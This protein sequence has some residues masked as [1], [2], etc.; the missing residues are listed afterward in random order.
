MCRNRFKRFTNIKPHL[1]IQIITEPRHAV[2]TSVSRLS[3]G[4]KVKYIIL[5]YVIYRSIAERKLEVDRLSF[6]TS[7]SEFKDL[8][9]SVTLFMMFSLMRTC[10]TF[11][12]Y[13]LSSVIKVRC[14]FCNYIVTKRRGIYQT[15]FSLIWRR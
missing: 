4:R 6:I 15:G 13:H 8:L 5:Y 12:I 7:D 14:L 11:Q 2:P 9:H 1:N 3:W 10:W